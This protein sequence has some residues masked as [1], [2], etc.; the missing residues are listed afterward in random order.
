MNQSTAP[1]SPQFPVL[2]RFLFV[3]TLLGLAPIGRPLAQQP[4]P[5]AQPVASPV[6]PDAAASSPSGSSANARPEQPAPQ[7]SA[8]AD[9]QSGGITEEQIKPLLLGKSLYLRNCYLDNS[10]SFSEHGA[11]TGH[12]VPGSYTLCGVEFNKVKLTKH[13]LE[14]YGD[15]FGLHFLGALPYEDPTKAVDRVRITTKKKILKV[16]IDREV[17]V[18]PKKIR[19]KKPGKIVAPISAAPPPAAATQPAPATQATTNATTPVAAPA[20]AA[21]A[22]TTAS[23]AAP[24]TLQVPAATT[25]P[26]SAPASPQ[27]T[28]ATPGKDKDDD[29]KDDASVP[30]ESDQLKASIAAAP[31][32]EKPA[33]PNSVT[34]TTSP[35]HAAQVLRDALDK[36]FAPGLDNRM[37][38]TMPDFWKLYYQAVA[39]RSDYRPAD[40]SVLRQNTVDKRARLLTSFEPA[41]N[42]FAQANGVAGMALY[43]VIIGPDGKPGEI[44][45]A[46]PIGFGLDENA[47]ESIRNARF[48]PALKNGKP[49]PVLLDLVVQF[50]IFSNRTAVKS[51][52]PTADNA[53]SPQPATPSKPSEPVLPGPFSRQQH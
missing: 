9:V 53:N 25:E 39:A 37:M 17:V 29:E 34:T 47:V 4:A 5:T 43:H 50:R 36:I 52:L 49:V 30:S 14:L 46:R 23:P 24:P 1:S 16:T 12:P 26:P 40:P 44:A 27:P 48:E 31:E 7:P 28:A 32:S 20:P 38:A 8:S 2:F 21:A 33:D 19:E 35:A 10:L 11:I 18:K 22:V 6:P 42:E 41:S 13:K 15:R 45:V 51:A 3:A